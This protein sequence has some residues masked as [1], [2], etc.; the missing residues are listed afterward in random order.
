MKDKVPYQIQKFNNHQEVLQKIYVIYPKNTDN[1]EWKYIQDDINYLKLYLDK[2][3]NFF[4]AE[5]A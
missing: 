1:W 4:K 5:K 2:L 3:S